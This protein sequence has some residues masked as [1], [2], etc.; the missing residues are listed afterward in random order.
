MKPE[1]ERLVVFERGI[2]PFS[3]LPVLWIGG[4]LPDVPF[5]ANSRVLVHYDGIIR[6]W[7]PLPGSM[8]RPT[9]RAAAV[10]ISKF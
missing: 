2:E 1:L 6:T 4:L 9:S 7:L 10:S 5:D 8:M 3:G